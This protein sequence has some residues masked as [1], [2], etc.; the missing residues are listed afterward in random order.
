MARIA[1]LTGGEQWERLAFPDPDVVVWSLIFHPH[2][3]RILYLGAAPASV[4]RSDN[5]GERWRR[6]D[7]QVSPRRTMMAVAVSRQDPRCVYGI[8]SIGQVFGTPDGGVTWTETP[9]PLG[10]RNVYAVAC[11]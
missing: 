3:P 9:L 7:H 6:F 2:N 8:N 5:G 11:G 1:A 4:Y 10:L